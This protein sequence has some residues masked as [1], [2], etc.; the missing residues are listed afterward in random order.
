MTL[1]LGFYQFASTTPER[2]GHSLA[3]ALVSPLYGFFFGYMA[4]ILRARVESINP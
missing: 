2:L 3:A 1:I 4:R